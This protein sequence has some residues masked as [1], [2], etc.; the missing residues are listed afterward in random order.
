MGVKLIDRSVR[1][2]EMTPAGKVFLMGCRDILDRYD[3]LTH[4]IARFGPSGEKIVRVDAIYSA[5]IDLLNH[6]KEAFELT[7]PE[8][9]VILEY[10]HPDEVYE[11]VRDRR[12]DLGI[13]SLSA[14]VARRAGRPPARRAD[15]CG[16]CARPPVGTTRS[17]R[18]LAAVRV[19]DGRVRTGP[20]SQPTDQ[21]IPQGT[22]RLTND[23]Q[24]V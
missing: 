3:R 24:R 21:A 17:S 7:H 13:V 5:G 23:R 6:V 20:T 4:R 8:N 19:V 2:L 10:K 9:S 11:T 14:A 1:P 16:L 18:R 15:G 22:R 12:C